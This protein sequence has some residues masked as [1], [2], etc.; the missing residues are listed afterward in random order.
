MALVC[1]PGRV[2]YGQAQRKALLAAALLELVSGTV[3]KFT[4]LS[5][6]C[7]SHLPHSQMR[8][9]THSW[10]YRQLLHEVQRAAMALRAAGHGTGSRIAIV[11]PMTPL[12]VVLYLATV[13]IG[14]AVVSVAESFS[15]A[16]MESRFAIG[17]VTLVVV[18]VGSLPAWHIT[19]SYL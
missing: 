14:A 16:E 10:S 8:C 6:R 1:S 9:R 4:Y 5:V 12:A 19:V 7:T 15:A 11:M 18:Q 17:D 13:Y 2:A 3:P